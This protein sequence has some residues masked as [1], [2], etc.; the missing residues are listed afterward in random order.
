LAV[1]PDGAIVVGGESYDGRGGFPMTLV[2][3][4]ASGAVDTVVTVPGSSGLAAVAAAPGGGVVAVGYRTIGGRRVPLVARFTAAGVLDSGGVASAPVGDADALPRALAVAPDGT[5]V[6]ASDAVR[7]GAA[8]IAVSRFAPGGGA[9]VTSFVAVPGRA[10]TAAGVAIDPSGRAVVAGTA[11]GGAGTEGLVTRL[12]PDGAPDPSFGGGAP[13]ILPGGMQLRALALGPDGAALL[14][15]SVR[16]PL[17]SEL[18][19]VRVLPDGTR[20]ASFGLG[21]LATAPAGTADAF[22]SGAA[23]DPAGTVV[24]AGAAS[25][26]GAATTALARLST[27]GGIDPTFGSAGVLAPSASTEGRS[28]AV[29]IDSAGRLLVA[30]SV[31]ADGREQLTLARYA[32]G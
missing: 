19:A 27:S 28:A 26:G 23:I 7:G 5:A 2:R 24:L 1:L 12:L 25:D 14:A 17:R 29:T 31:F 32:G 10:A 4:T 9:P 6:V 20:D 11:Q 8:A 3:F 22:A 30:G 21:G 18:A 13:V 15:G 16:A